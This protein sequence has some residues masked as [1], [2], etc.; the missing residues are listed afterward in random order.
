MLEKL[1]N[2]N[3]R[4]SSICDVENVMLMMDNQKYGRRKS[5]HRKQNVNKLTYHVHLKDISRTILQGSLYLSVTANHN[6]VSI[7][8]LPTH[9]KHTCCS[10]GAANFLKSTCHFAC[11]FDD[12]AE[13]IFLGFKWSK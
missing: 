6:L 2:F 3:F 10:D 5:I 11:L 4:V 9:S 1:R 7:F 12:M 8:V 13:S